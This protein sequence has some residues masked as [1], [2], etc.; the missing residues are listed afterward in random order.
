M[1]FSD[2]IVNNGPCTDGKVVHRTWLATDPQNPNVNS[3]CVQTIKLDDHIAP[4]FNSCPS[5]IV[6]SGNGYNCSVPVSWT[7]PTVTDNCGL[8]SLI[9]HDQ[10]G[11][12]VNSG[13]SFTQGTHTITYTATDHCGNTSN[14]SF[15]ITVHCV[16]C[17]TP[18]VINCPADAWICIGESTSPQDHGYATATGGPYC[19]APV[20]TYQDWI[21]STGPCPGQKTIKRVWTASYQGT[22]GLTSSCEQLLYVEDFGGPVIY[23]CPPEHYRSL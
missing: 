12:V 17:N 3:S 2:Q 7:V 16:T 10:N 1:T 4:Y 21:M 5:N 6:V 14:C 13:M 22:G 19:P 15:T 18:P 9:A 11:Y 23:G 20:V 8:G